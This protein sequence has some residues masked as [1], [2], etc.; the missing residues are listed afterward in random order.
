MVLDSSLHLTLLHCGPSLLV[1]R[2]ELECVTDLY[3][4][5]Q[6]TCAFSTFS[7]YRIELE[8]ITDLYLVSLHSVFRRHHLIR[9]T[10]A[11]ELCVQADCVACILGS[12]SV[13]VLGSGGELLV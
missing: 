12:A 8:C 2:N 13:R 1:F 6:H 7:L 11:S 3:L 10:D 9:V 4:L 5:H